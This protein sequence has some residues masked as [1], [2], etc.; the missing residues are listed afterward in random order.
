[1]RDIQTLTGVIQ[2]PYGPYCPQEQD[3]YITAQFAIAVRLSRVAD[4]SDY[5]AVSWPGMA[6]EARF[7]DTLDEPR[8]PT[9][10]AVDDY[11]REGT[12][13]PQ[14]YQWIVVRPFLACTRDG[15]L[16]IRFD[17]ENTLRESNE[18]D[19]VLRLRYSTVP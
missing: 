15:I 19:N 3:A 9:G 6:R 14:G 12:P 8:F 2:L 5:I 4:P 11:G 7:V 10:D 1:V 16:E 18:G 13:L 17:P